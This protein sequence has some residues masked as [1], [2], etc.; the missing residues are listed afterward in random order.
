V[1][2]LDAGQNVDHA[3]RQLE[4]AL[5]SS[6]VTNG[7]YM[8]WAQ[9]VLDGLVIPDKRRGRKPI[10][11]TF[12]SVRKRAVRAGIY[13]HFVHVM[14]GTE[15]AIY[16]NHNKI[17]HANNETTCIQKLKRIMATSKK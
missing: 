7:N 17:A 15:Y 1:D 4:G 11:E 5:S 16:R 2:S 13:I 6:V 14:E 12:D 8:A 3:L 9:D 10:T